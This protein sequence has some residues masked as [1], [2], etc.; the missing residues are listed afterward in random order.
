MYI[1]KNSLQGDMVDCHP[2]ESTDD[3]GSASVNYVS[4]G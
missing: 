1:K 4:S 3:L 2:S